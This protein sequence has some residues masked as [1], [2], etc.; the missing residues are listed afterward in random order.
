MTSIYGPGDR[1][2]QVFRLA[3]VRC[4]LLVTFTDTELQARAVFD[5][6][7]ETVEAR[8]PLRLSP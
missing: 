7:V 5:A 4:G 1:R 2:V 3:A 8:K 6:N